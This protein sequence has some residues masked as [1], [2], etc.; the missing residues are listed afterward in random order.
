MLVLSLKITIYE[1]RIAYLMD[2]L[3]LLSMY[4]EKCVINNK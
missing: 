1:K 4:S 2:E 3:Q